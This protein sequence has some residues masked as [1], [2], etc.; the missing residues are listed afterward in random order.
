M[1]LLT[2]AL[3]VVG[4]A[5]GP[6]LCDLLPVRIYTSF[7]DIES[8]IDIFVEDDPSLSTSIFGIFMLSRGVGNIL[9]TPVST[10]LQRVQFSQSTVSL[11]GQAL[12][13]YK[14]AGGQYERMIIYVGTCFAGAAVIVAT[15]WIA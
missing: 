14:V 15:G 9:S 10:A 13:G 8:H 6:V 1:G 4:Q 12:N 5:Y 7:V 2:V 11:T 3:P